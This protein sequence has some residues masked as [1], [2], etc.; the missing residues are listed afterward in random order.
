[1]IFMFFDTGLLMQ[2]WKK[3]ILRIHALVELIYKF[4]EAYGNWKAILYYVYNI[5]WSPTSNHKCTP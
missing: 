4:L 2:I 1:M 5:Y 3:R